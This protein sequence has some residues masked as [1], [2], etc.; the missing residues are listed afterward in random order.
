MGGREHG[1]AKA[2]P[3]SIPGE[4]TRAKACCPV[5]LK[6]LLEPVSDHV[7]VERRGLSADMADVVAVVERREHV[8]SRCR[9]S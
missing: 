4:L 8:E 1:W 5:S 7:V 3:S 9:T 6:S 2:G